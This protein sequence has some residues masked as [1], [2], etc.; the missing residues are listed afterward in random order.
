MN[1]LKDAT[2]ISVRMKL[3]CMCQQL[4]KDQ[5]EEVYV[6]ACVCV[7]VC[8][9]VGVGVGGCVRCDLVCISITTLA[10]FV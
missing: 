7:W 3:S 4:L 2:P 6:C 5:A 9:C 1:V 8:G 10:Y